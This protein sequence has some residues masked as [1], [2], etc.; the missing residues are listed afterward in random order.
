MVVYG[1]FA[2]LAGARDLLLDNLYPRDV[3]HA[4][5]DVLVRV[6]MPL[7]LESVVEIG[8]R[9]L[10]YAIGCAAIALVSVA[11]ARGGRMRT[12]ATAAVALFGTA[13][14]GAALLRPEALRHGL[15][16]IYAWIPAGALIALVI[17]VRKRRRNGTSDATE[18]EIVGLTALFALGLSSYGAFYLHAPH[19]RWPSTRCRWRRSSSLAYICAISFSTAPGTSSVPHGSSFSS[20]LARALALKDARIE[21][22]SVQGPRGLDSGDRR[23]SH[24]LFRRAELDRAQDDARA[25]GS[26]WLR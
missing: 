25:T 23:G 2:R 20:P 21:T 19:P 16:F 4:G 13:A 8:G 5:G 6:R 15:Q 22:A 9:V 10:L 7:T 17:V 24:A 18:R 26:S 14:I 11:V 12:I 1:I 3:L